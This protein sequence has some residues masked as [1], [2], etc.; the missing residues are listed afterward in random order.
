LAGIITEV[1]WRLF[2]AE[3]YRQRG[4]G[5]QSFSTEIR[6]GRVWGY[7][8]TV[9][10]KT[11]SAYRRDPETG[12]IIWDDLPLEYAFRKRADLSSQVWKAA[13]EQE[14]KIFDVIRGGRALGRDVKDIGKDL[15]TFIN[16]PNGGERV[17][18]RWKSMFP[19]TEQGRREAWKREYL[20]AHGGLQP[21]SQAARALLREPD[22]RSWV[23]QKMAETTQRGTPRLPDAVKQYAS[24]L[25][26]AGLDYRAIR[27]S[28]TETAAMLADEQTDIARNSA[29]STGEMD[30]VMER[31]RDAWGCNCEKY[32]AQS[33]WKVDD[34]ARPEIPVHPNCGCVWRPRLKTDAEMMASFR[35]RMKEAE[36]GA[37]AGEEGVYSASSS[38]P[39]SEVK[40]YRDM[41]ISRLSYKKTEEQN[42]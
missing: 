25:G 31:G 2:E 7:G 8:V 39:D 14:Q 35:E 37:S 34:P 10:G 24:R 21:G 11:V 20:A 36:A 6:Q 30:F 9:S 40:N 15:E 33:P 3:Y 32:A 23:K 1:Q 26:K 42:L 18:G 22:A 41:H 29:I 12:K 27:I 4:T 19:N 17:V 5:R 13:E 28:R 16:Y 38:N